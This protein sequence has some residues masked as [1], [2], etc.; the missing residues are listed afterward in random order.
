VTFNDVNSLTVDQVA[1]VVDTTFAVGEGVNSGVTSTM[2]FVDLRTQAGDLTVAVNNMVSAGGVN[3]VNNLAVNF[4]AVAADTAINLN[5]E[6]MVVSTVGSHRYTADNM[7]FSTTTKIVSPVSVS[8]RNTTA[9][10]VIDLGSTDIN[11]V[12][13]TLALSNAELNQIS[14]PLLAIGRNT[15][16]GTGNIVISDRIEPQAT[17]VIAP[18]DIPETL[19]L[20][21]PAM[22]VDTNGMT[23]GAIVEDN[24]FIE[25]GDG[26]NLDNTMAHDVDVLAARISNPGGSLFFRDVDDLIVGTV[27]RLTITGADEFVDATMTVDGIITDGRT[28]G[29]VGGDV[30]LV[31]E[32]P[33]VTSITVNQPIITTASG[34]GRNSGAITL[35]TVMG[36][37]DID[38]NSALNTMGSNAEGGDITLRTFNGV[39]NIN[40]PGGT[41]NA[42]GGNPMFGR[43]NITIDANGQ[44][45]DVNIVGNLQTNDVA[46]GVVRGSITITADDSVFIGNLTPTA[47]SIQT[48]GLGTITI[49]ANDSALDGD[50]DGVIVM[51]S[52]TST[53][54]GTGYRHAANPQPNGR[55]RWVD[56]RA[57][58]Q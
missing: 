42:L 49:T 23:I 16:A 17:N 32:G 18:M 48:T 35:R 52:M 43:G 33:G 31:S 50:N 44:N 54:T 15:G 20:I 30:E 5:A 45:S 56:H 14:T 22:V 40:T 11:M 55:R 39:I 10:V 21:T 12:N 47:V 6:T 2:S 46:G 26:A 24:L 1:D 3:G 19:H 37:G 36:T 51:Q 9:G 13:A 34:G 4:L 25:A 41:L 27:N 7:A 57:A 28:A 58:D 29:N 53:H 38:I 8:L